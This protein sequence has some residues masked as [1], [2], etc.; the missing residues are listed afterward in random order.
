MQP[1]C[2]GANDECATPQADS[3]PSP[4]PPKEVERIASCCARWRCM[5]A[6][7]ASAVSGRTTRAHRKASP[8]SSRYV[9]P[10]GTQ[11]EAS[12]SYNVLVRA[13]LDLLPYCVPFAVLF[14]WS[15]L[16]C[17]GLVL[18]T[19]LAH[20]RVHNHR[21][22]RDTLL[23][24]PVSRASGSSWTSGNPITVKTVMGLLLPSHPCR[25]ALCAQMNS[26]CSRQAQRQ[27]Q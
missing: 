20:A 21:H 6:K 1:R 17:C 27:P 8:P 18:L 13:C 14:C 9:P 22:S 23:A 19:C 16:P 26:I 2:T 4:L 15:L 24:A 3:S 10:R 7:G 12:C 5:A 11:H 25:I